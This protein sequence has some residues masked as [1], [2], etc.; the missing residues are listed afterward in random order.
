MI[1]G[2]RVLPGRQRPPARLALRRVLSEQLAVRAR[3]RGA[4]PRAG[5][6]GV[7][8]LRRRPEPDPR[9][10]RILENAPRRRVCRP[11]SFMVGAHVQRYPEIARRV[12]AARTS[13]RQPHAAPHQAARAR[14]APDP[15]GAG[16]GARGNHHDCRGDAAGHSERPTAIATRSLYRRRTVSATMCSVG[17]SACGTSAR[18]GAEEIRRR[19]R[20][21]T[22]ARAP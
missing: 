1:A 13:G 9:T 10:D 14:A 4:G 3:D 12:V 7:S 5:E 2:G 6:N 15:P 17:R 8:H 11:P 16:A 21:N 19:V 22:S 18:P 20:K